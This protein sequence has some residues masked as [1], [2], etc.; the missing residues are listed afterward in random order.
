MYSNTKSNMHSLCGLRANPQVL[1]KPSLLIDSVRLLRAAA[2][3][4]NY[5]QRPPTEAPPQP[6][7]SWAPAGNPLS[8][9]MDGLIQRFYFKF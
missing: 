5:R 1:S 9:A 3:K 4:L 8:Q 2:V 6:H 7:G